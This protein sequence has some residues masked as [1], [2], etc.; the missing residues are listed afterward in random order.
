M[1]KLVRRSVVALIIAWLNSGQPLPVGSG[2]ESIASAQSPSAKKP[3]A[4][5]RGPQVIELPP[6]AS[7][8]FDLVA[9]EAR[10]PFP[11][12]LNAASFQ[13]RLKAGGTFSLSGGDLV[14][15]PPSFS[16]N[17]TLFMAL[18]T[19]ELKRG[20]RL[21]TNGNALIIFVNKLISEDGKVI[22]FL[23]P[24]REAADGDSAGEPGDPG[25]PG[26]LVSIHVVQELSGILH[27]DLSGQNGGNGATGAV[28]PQGSAGQKGE[29]GVNQVCCPPECKRGGQ[30]GTPGHRGGK[31][32]AGGAAG[33]GG[34]GGILELFNVGATPI[35][36]ERFTFV[37]K[38][39]TPGTPGVGGNGGPGGP[40]G[41]GG[42]GDGLCGGGGQGPSGPAGPSGDAG[43]QAKKPEEGQAIVKNVDL[44]F[45]L[46]K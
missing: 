24:N 9:Q 21:V 17:K 16:D 39:G 22:S 29:K 30:D 12:I 38:A 45:F 6:G 10:A 40:G 43:S 3:P 1:R 33:N 27:V 11:Q 26:R 32:S 34:A 31:G 20:A 46:K 13:A 37:A 8:P 41:Q 19:L 36:S 15:G 42:D 2:T 44:E 25:V 18:D 5:S 28:G 4:I 35:P 23:E 7:A 14:L